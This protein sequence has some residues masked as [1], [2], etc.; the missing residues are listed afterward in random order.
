MKNRNRNSK[1]TML[2]GTLCAAASM[3]L[4]SGCAGS[5]SVSGGIKTPA[6]MISGTLTTTSNSVGVTGSYQTGGTNGT[7]ITGGVTVVK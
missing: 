4:M 3:C 7:N 5:V 6:E 1:L 2:A